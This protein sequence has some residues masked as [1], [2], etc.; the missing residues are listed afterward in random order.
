MYWRKDQSTVLHLSLFLGRFTSSRRHS[1]GYKDFPYS[2][3]RMS[4]S[5]SWINKVSG[6]VDTKCTEVFE[7]GYV[8]G[9]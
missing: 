8:D 6:E 5:F 4:F 3:K 2:D 7:D 1:L 9:W